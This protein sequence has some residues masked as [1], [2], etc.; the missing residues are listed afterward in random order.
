METI[1]DRSTLKVE[2]RAYTTQQC[3]VRD[4]MPG[5]GL[6]F[7]GVASTVDSPYLVRDS[8]G[9]FTET[10]QAGA[11]DKTL[12]ENADVGLFIDHAGVP[13]ARTRAKTMTLVAD[14]H[15]RAHARLDGDRPDVQIIRSA[16]RRGEV[17]QMSIGFRVHKQ[18]WNA[19]YTERLIREAQLFDVSIVAFPANPETSAQVRALVRDAESMT[20]PNELRAAMR[21]LEAA[22]AALEPPVLEP[23]PEPD[24]DVNERYERLRVRLRDMNGPV[25]RAG[26]GPR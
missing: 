19:D 9:D 12:A 21:R 26:A 8:F 25:S 7:E 20:N 6:T 16:L 1:Q 22:L 4:D 5:D 10:I 14:P 3:E 24:E 18:E 2:K 11:F 23:V 17:D 13:L 15:L